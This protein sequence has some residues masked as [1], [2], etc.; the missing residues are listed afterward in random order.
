MKHIFTI[1]LLFPFLTEAQDTTAP[2]ISNFWTQDTVLIG[3]FSDFE[4]Q[5]PSYSIID[6]VD[7]DI[8]AQ[9]EIVNEV[10][11]DSLGFYEF[12][13]SAKDKAENSISQSVVIYIADTVAPIIELYG[14][15]WNFVGYGEEYT[16]YGV[17]I[18]ENYFDMTDVMLNI[19]GT[20]NNTWHQGRF[21]ITYQAIDASSNHSLIHYRVVCVEL[22]SMECI[23]LPGELCEGVRTSLSENST[24]SLD[25]YP[26]P[27]KGHFNVNSD[28]ELIEIYNTKGLLISSTIDKEFTL[29]KHGV[30]LLKAISAEGTTYTKK[31]IVE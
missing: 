1:L 30:Y 20:F 3:V 25:I 4:S 2:K 26:N 17:S 14:P 31:L 6:N 16:N 5:V 27:S 11:E 28:V 7:G 21:C 29:D 13:V 10:N 15:K 23:S 8:T 22:D 12:T 9:A 19:G 24:T 18:S